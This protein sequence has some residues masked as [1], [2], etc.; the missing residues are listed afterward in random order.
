MSNSLVQFSWEYFSATTRALSSISAARPLV[1]KRAP[2][3]A[4]KGKRAPVGA[5]KTA[6]RNQ[7]LKCVH[8]PADRAARAVEPICR[9]SENCKKSKVNVSNTFD[10]SG[11]GF[12]RSLP[13]FGSILPILSL[14]RCR[15]VVPANFLQFPELCQ[16][17]AAEGLVHSGAIRRFKESTKK[18]LH[19]PYTGWCTPPIDTTSTLYRYWLA[20]IKA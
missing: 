9:S 2:V 11:R 7:G 5:K 10:Y 20:S 1:T 3:G 18:G 4:S 17:V 16:A 19:T 12:C 8:Q 6:T 15:Q 14:L 13:F